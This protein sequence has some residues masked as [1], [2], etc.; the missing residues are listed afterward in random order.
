MIREARARNEDLRI[1][2]EIGDIRDSFTFP[3]GEFDLVVA[4]AM[5]HWIEDQQNALKNVYNCIKSGGL[6]VGHTFSGGIVEEIFFNLIISPRWQNFV[7]KVQTVSNF[8]FRSAFFI[9]SAV[10]LVQKIHV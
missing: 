5:M 6:F 3:S 10:S 8:F 4:S 9:Q 7:D 2:Y 1:K